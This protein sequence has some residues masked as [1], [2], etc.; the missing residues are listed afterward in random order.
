M[1]AHFT[2]PTLPR[3]PLLRGL[4]LAATV[5]TLVGLVTMGLVV[6]TVIF[7]G[8]ALML[9]IRGWLS[10]RASRATDPSVIEGEFTVVSPRHREGLPRP[11]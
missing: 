5:I 9:T 2:I 6:G 7:A 10:R 1:R 4:V 11:E 3:N 8:A